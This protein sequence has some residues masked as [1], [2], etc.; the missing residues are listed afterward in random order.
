[1]SSQA[2]IFAALSLAPDLAVLPQ[3]NVQTSAPGLPVAADVICYQGTMVAYDPA[4]S[5]AQPADPAMAATAVVIGVTEDTIDND[6]GAKGAKKIKPRAGVW[7]MKS[8]GN[9]TAAH[10]YKQVRVVDDHTVGVPA[11][12]NADRFAGILLGLDGDFAW[13]LILPGSAERGPVTVTLTSTNGTAA[14]AADLTALKAE[15]E[16]IGDDV[17][18]IHAALVAQGLIAPAA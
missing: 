15:A 9:L 1:M 12:T 17:R 8:D 13:I 16:K 2:G 10:L 5:Q 4:N 7:R 6:G 18:A 11:G 3:H 14:A